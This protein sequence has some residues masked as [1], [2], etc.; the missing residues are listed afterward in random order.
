VLTTPFKTGPK[1]LQRVDCIRMIRRK[2][3]RPKPPSRWPGRLVGL[4][5]IGQRRLDRG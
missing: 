5:A 2:K 3:G 4:A 1:H